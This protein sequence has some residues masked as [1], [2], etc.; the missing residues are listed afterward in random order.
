MKGFA[1]VVSLS[2][3]LAA[4]SAGD[5]LSNGTGKRL[6]KTV[7]IES[8]NGPPGVSVNNANLELA[9]TARTLKCPAAIKTCMIEVE[10]T[11]NWVVANTGIM[12][13]KMS[14]NGVPSVTGGAVSGAVLGQ[15]QPAHWK[16]TRNVG[17][18]SHRVRFFVSTNAAQ[19]LA[20]YSLTASIYAR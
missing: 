14:I 20:A 8:Y 15:Y 10:M 4:I 17:A 19:F 9:G 7:S 6:L 18:G 13:N 2:A 12:L 5:A 3:L 16:F 11:T 1:I